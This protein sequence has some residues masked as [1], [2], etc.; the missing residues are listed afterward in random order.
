[1]EIPS[2]PGPRSM[3][4]RPI[5]LLTNRLHPDGEALLAPEVRLV[6]APDATPETLRRLV[7]DADGIIVRARLP[8]DIV[9]H[10][11]RLKGI[12]RHGVGLDFIPVEKASARG[13][14]VADLPGCN[15]Q[16]VAEYVFAALLHLRRNGRLREPQVAGVLVGDGVSARK[17]GRRSEKEGCDES[18]HR[19]AS[20]GDLQGE[21]RARSRSG[22]ERRRVPL[23]L[24][25]DRRIRPV[26]QESM[27]NRAGGS[28]TARR[29]CRTGRKVRG[30]RNTTREEELESA[31]SAE[32]LRPVNGNTS[33]PRWHW[34]LMLTG[35]TWFTSGSTSGPITSGLDPKIA[36][37]CP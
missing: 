7:A 14:A 2:S 11:P 10:G 16:A 12:V 33:G 4:E 9:E 24:G 3:T 29:R 34:Q 23:R 13:I 8:D 18:A 22:E 15:T 28:R 36:T 35:Q 32:S 37:C 1:M 26:E 17:G 31:G 25:G 5:V 6:V 27:R 30:G 21:R 19:C 20:L